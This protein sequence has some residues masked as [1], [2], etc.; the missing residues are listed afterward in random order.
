LAVIYIP[1]KAMV[2]ASISQGDD[3]IKIVFVYK[4]FGQMLELGI[5]LG[6]SY[7]VGLG[8]G[9]LKRLL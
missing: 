5:K 1:T 4:V 3:L 2:V 7:L 6:R 8:P 9:H